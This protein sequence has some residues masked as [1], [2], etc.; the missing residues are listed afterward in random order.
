ML[1]KCHT[2]KNQVLTCIGGW[3]ISRV[4][5]ILHEGNLKTKLSKVKPFKY[6]GENSFLGHF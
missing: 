2:T 3:G 1:D 6:R 4:V 5:N